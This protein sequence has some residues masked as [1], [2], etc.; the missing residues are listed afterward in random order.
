MY[1]FQS[2]CSTIE[3]IDLLLSSMMC[4][5]LILSSLVILQLPNWKKSLQDRI[6]RPRHHVK[7]R[8]DQAEV[9]DLCQIS[10]YDVQS[11]ILQQTYQEALD[12]PW[13]AVTPSLDG[14]TNRG[15]KPL[16]DNLPNSLFQLRR[17]TVHVQHLTSDSTQVPPFYRLEMYHFDPC[18]LHNFYRMDRFQKLVPSHGSDHQN[19]PDFKKSVQKLP[20]FVVH[21]LAIVDCKD[22][23]FDEALRSNAS[24]KVVWVKSC[25]VRRNTT[26]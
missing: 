8:T 17:Q 7:R 10:F 19:V 24:V 9:V 11:P 25:V 5:H 12:P 18:V 15:M 3:S 20:R 4:C 1:L 23:H 6:Q 22:P 2:S 14:A 26:V 16:L 13:I 21:E